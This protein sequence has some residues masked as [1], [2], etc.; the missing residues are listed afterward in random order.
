MQFT[1]EHEDLRR[2]IRKWIDAEVNP[3]TEEWEASGMYPARKV[4]KQMGDLGLLGMT[5]PEAYGGAGL[6]LSY[7]AVLAYELGWVKS[8]GVA[9][10]IGVQ[11]DMCTPALANVGSP[12]LCDAFLRPAIAGDL[13]G[14]IGVSEPQAGSDVSAIRTQAVKDGDDYVING[15]K[16]WITNGVQADFCVLLANTSEGQVHQNKSLIVVPM[17]TPGVSVARKIDKLGMWS[18]DTA[19]LHF[20]DVRVPQ[21]NLVGE[22]G[23]GFVYQMQQF[24]DERLWGAIHAAGAMRRALD[25]TYEYLEDRSTFGKPIIRNQYVAF[26]M[27]ELEVEWEAFYSLCL[28][29]YD[30]AL[31]GRDATR[32]ATLAKLKAGRL[33]REL[34]DQCLQFW[35]GMGYASDSEINRIF[36]D[37]RLTAIGGG[38]DEVMLQIL[39]KMPRG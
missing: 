22:E 3:H 8:G 16:M 11:T 30:E 29:G 17:D 5:K 9:L 23:R 36:R 39:T 20:D 27:A 24:Q 13:V 38:A 2:T 6:D 32:L 31:A 4:M 10:S 12:E 19:Q 33:T 37:G 26:R 21:S 34:N 25:C 7:G 18:S 14:C 15:A 1:S 35:G 28:R